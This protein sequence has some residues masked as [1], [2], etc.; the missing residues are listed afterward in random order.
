VANYVQ[1]CHANIRAFFL[2]RSTKRYHVANRTPGQHRVTRRFPVASNPFSP[3]TYRVTHG[4]TACKPNKHAI[5]GIVAPGR[6]I[7]NRSLIL[8]VVMI[9]GILRNGQWGVRWRGLHL[10]SPHKKIT[11][12]P[13]F[14]YKSRT[15]DDLTGY[16]RIVKITSRQHLEVIYGYG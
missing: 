11:F 8:S 14:L 5:V 4:H 15:Y 7:G 13:L 10:F 9:V 16:L 3:R 1:S 12:I 2:C 6:S